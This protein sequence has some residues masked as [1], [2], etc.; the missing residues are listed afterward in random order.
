MCDKVMLCTERSSSDAWSS[1]VDCVMG[2]LIRSLGDRIRGK[3]DTGNI[4]AGICY[5]SPGREDKIDE[6][7]SRKVEEASLFQALAFIGYTDLPEICWTGNTVGHKQS[8]F[9]EWVRDN[10]LAQ[11]LDRVSREML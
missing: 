3:A 8:R 10:F 11:V 6:A 2:W 5:R 4:V 1:A 9:L 7:F